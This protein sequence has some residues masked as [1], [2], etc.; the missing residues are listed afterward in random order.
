MSFQQNSFNIAMTQ[1][2]FVR[3]TE[4]E[5]IRL[6]NDKTTSGDRYVEEFQNIFFAS[7]CYKKE[8]KILKANNSNLKFFVK[9][10]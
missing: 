4:I 2:F 6:D 5:L 1:S 10:F 3:S 9:S 8:G 7:F